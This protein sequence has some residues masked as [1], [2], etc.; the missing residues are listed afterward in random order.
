MYFSVIIEENECTF[1]N[2]NFIVFEIL[3]HFGR[4]WHFGSSVDIDFLLLCAETTH[5][6]SYH[7]LLVQYFTPIAQY[8]HYLYPFVEEQRQTNTQTFVHL[9]TEPVIISPKGR[10]ETCHGKSQTVVNISMV[11]NKGRIIQKSPSTN[12]FDQKNW[13]GISVWGSQIFYDF[14]C[15]WVVLLPEKFRQLI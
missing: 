10:Y 5:S 6:L 11:Q 9:N 8:F 1:L 7:N 2:E 12:W 4:I 3:S 15:W 14:G 13:V